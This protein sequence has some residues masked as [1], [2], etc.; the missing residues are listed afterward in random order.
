VFPATIIAIVVAVGLSACLPTTTPPTTTAPTN[1][2][3]TTTATTP[4]STTTSPAT[5]AVAGSAQP[6]AGAQSCDSGATAFLLATANTNGTAATPLADP[7]TA[8]YPK[9]LPLPAC[10]VLW[11]NTHALPSYAGLYPNA[12]EADFAALVTQLTANG[13]ASHDPGVSVP[14]IKKI[15]V[16]AHLTGGSASESG[17]LVLIDTTPSKGISSPTIIFTWERILF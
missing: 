17:T 13:I 8:G 10:A 14:G 2:A 12:T 1:T 15:L 7:A 3:P 11:T 4:N 5:S 6:S 9:F 16:L